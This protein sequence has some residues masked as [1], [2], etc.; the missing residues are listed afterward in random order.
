MGIGKLKRSVYG[1]RGDGKRERAR[2]RKMSKLTM[3]TYC[4]MGW[5][6]LI[7]LF[8]GN[9]LHAVLFSFLFF[10]FCFPGGGGIRMIKQIWVMTLTAAKSVEVEIL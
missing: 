8:V 3:M 6:I 9:N 5:Q 4:F 10:F 2:H 7:V 1:E